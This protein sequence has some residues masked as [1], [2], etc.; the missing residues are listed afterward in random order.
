M[1]LTNPR[2]SMALTQETSCLYNIFSAA[3]QSAKLLF[4]PPLVIENHTRTHTQN[5]AY[6]LELCNNNKHLIDYENHTFL[7]MVTDKVEG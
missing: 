7:Q 5:R 3:V 6:C 2:A 1:T 4:L